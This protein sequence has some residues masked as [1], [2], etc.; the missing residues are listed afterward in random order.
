MY[1]LLPF[2]LTNESTKEFTK[3]FTKGFTKG[4]IKGLGNTTA[5]LTVLGLLSGA[6]YIYN[7]GIYFIQKSKKCEKSKSVTFVKNDI[8][9]TFF[10]ED[11]NETQ[12]DLGDC[13]SFENSNLVVMKKESVKD[14]KD[15]DTKDKDTKDKDTKY[16]KLLERLF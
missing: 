10:Y 1:N 5:T 16:K 2:I 11:D 3:E 14:I 13:A 9:S 8:D 12:K 7:N 15:K 6:W 4:F